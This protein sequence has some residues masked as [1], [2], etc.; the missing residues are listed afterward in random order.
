MW[1]D[2]MPLIIEGKH[3]LHGEV[4][5]GGAKNAALPIIAATLLTGDECLLENVPYIEDIRNIVRLLQNLG[6]AVRFE[7][8]NTLRIKATRISRAE[9]PLE[10]T[11]KMRASFLI[12]GPLLARFGQAESYH[13]GGCAIGTRP[14]S[15]DLKGFQTMSAQVETLDDRYIIRAPRL[16][17]ERIML[18]YPSHTGTENLMMAACLA[19]G[20]TIIE[21]ASVEPEV[22]DL[23]GFLCAMGARVYGAGTN[24]IRI[25]GT[26]RLHGAAYR[27]MPDRMEAGTFALGALITGGEVVMDGAVSH[28]LGALTNKMRDAGA[29]VH[30]DDDRYV[31]TARGPLRATDIQTYPYP[32]FPTD[33][34]APFTTMLTQALGNSSV[35]ETMYDGRLGYVNEL[36]RMGGRITVSGSGRTAMVHGPT[37]LQGADVFALDIR[38][39]AAMVLAGLC[40]EGETC[41]N[42]VVYIDRGYEQLA[43]KLCGLSAVVHRVAESEH[44]CPKVD[45]G[46]PIEW[47][48]VTM[49]K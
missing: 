32:G 14:V 35:H 15:V 21:N 22:V 17:G 8:G 12:A 7:G 33:L 36:A 40:A 41:I 47:Q 31:V 30:A 39:G 48:M 37:P 6:V 43:A 23:A 19:H 13:P 3:P 46:E 18:D 11:K 20:T 49:G 1:G 45:Y 4:E 29:E 2:D 26:H 28:W 38:S 10:L 5:I 24:T 25:E 27:I 42:N 16:Q 9:L 34:Q 44:Q